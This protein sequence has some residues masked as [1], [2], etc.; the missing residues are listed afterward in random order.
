MIILD[1]IV[2]IAGFTFGALITL[3]FTT[4]KVYEIKNVKFGMFRE[5]K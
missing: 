4:P 2:F 1:I 3:H 5:I